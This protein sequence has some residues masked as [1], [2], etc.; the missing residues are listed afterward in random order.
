MTRTWFA[1]CALLVLAA[2]SWAQSGNSQG[3]PG[4]GNNGRRPPHGPEIPA[5][6]GG[7]GGL[8]LGAGSLSDPAVF[9]GLAPNA[10]GLGAPF[11]VTNA[12]VQILRYV[13]EE[14]LDALGKQLALN[15]NKIGAWTS[16]FGDFVDQGTVFRT[17]GMALGVDKVTRH[18]MLGVTGGY[19]HTWSNA[20]SANSGWGGLYG[21]A[22]TNGWYA[23]G[24]VY[25]GAT[26]F[27][28]TRIGVSGTGNATGSS[29]T[30]FFGTFFETGKLWQCGDLRFGPY[31]LLQ[32]GLD[33]DIGYN[34]SGSMAPL[35]VNASNNDSITTDVG[36]RLSWRW[37]SARVAWEHEYAYS[38]IVSTVHLLAAPVPSV[39]VPGPPL[40]HDSLIVNAGVSYDLSK[41]TSITLQYDGQLARKN[42]MSN[43]VSATFRVS[44]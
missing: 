2:S 29:H 20:L 10:G 38:A 21:G 44:F 34:E 8:S 35:R 25:G 36:G 40:G 16:P 11:G 23:S 39:A 28:T 31:G 30:Y 26:G 41:C 27:T 7:L 13:L 22:W 32:Y 3:G 18:W 24:A 6:G 9:R 33:R 12:T 37:L 17:G 5:G 4:G 15:F 43:G 42:F 19:S 1:I 14:R